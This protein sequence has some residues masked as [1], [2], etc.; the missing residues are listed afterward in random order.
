M[1][2]YMLVIVE[3]VAIELIK[4]GY[5]LVAQLPSERYKGR[6]I[7]VFANDEDLERDILQYDESSYYPNA[8]MVN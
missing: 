2:K 3:S 1:E 5:N 8:R 4:K 7:F 6:R